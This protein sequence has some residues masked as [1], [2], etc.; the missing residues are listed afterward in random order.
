MKTKGM[1]T[2]GTGVNY[3]LEGIGR[4]SGKLSPAAFAL[5]ARSDDLDA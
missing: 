1:K 4:G 3:Y 2:K 5:P